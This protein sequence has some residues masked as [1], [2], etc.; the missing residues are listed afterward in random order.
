MASPILV[1]LVATVLQF[2]IPRLC[3]LFVFAHFTDTFRRAA[4]A[5]TWLVDH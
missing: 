1:D 4:V 2:Y 3:C 5:G